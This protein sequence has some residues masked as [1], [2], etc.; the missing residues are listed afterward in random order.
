[1]T[2]VV[3][4]VS[5]H[6]RGLNAV[7]TVPGA[8]VGDSLGYLK[9]FFAVSSVGTVEIE[10]SCV[11]FAARS[12]VRRAGRYWGAFFRPG[13]P[14]AEH[15]SLVSLRSLV[16]PLAR[17]RGGNVAARGNAFAVRA[18]IGCA[19]RQRDDERE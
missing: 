7:V 11:G 18:H 19:E 15:R 2:L 12:V 5:A 3:V 16:V 4:Y 1:M 10:A 8:L 17:Q 6:H 9:V 14:V 13:V